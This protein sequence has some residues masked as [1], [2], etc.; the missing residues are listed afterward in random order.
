MYRVILPVRGTPA[1]ASFQLLLQ[2]LSPFRLDP[3]QTLFRPMPR[4]VSWPLLRILL[5]PSIHLSNHLGHLS[6]L[7]GTCY[8]IRPG[9]TVDTSGHVLLGSY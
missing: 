1:S 9:I 5:C 8:V 6:A 7:A 3:P 2:P 4:T